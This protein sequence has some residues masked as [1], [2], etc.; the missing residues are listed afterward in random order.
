MKIGRAQIVDEALTL[1]N[2]SGL[3]QL[4]TRKLAERLNIQQP[5]LYYHFK[6]K[7]MLVD[8]MNTRMLAI[9]HTDRFPAV[10]DDWQTYLL[11]NATSFRRALLSHRD[12]ARVHAGSHAETPDLPMAEAQLKCLIDVGFK[13]TLALQVLVT[14][15]R[16][17]VGSVLEQQAEESSPPEAP[18]DVAAFPH[19]SA[20]F[21]H[22]VASSHEANFTAGLSFILDGASK[23][24]DA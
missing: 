19:L 21:S 6:N 5:T 18:G 23:A 4:S 11:A 2:E 22:Y 3:D 8:A 1:L 13:P 17:V 12:G 16:F 9:G 10:G 20:A 14:L 24:L 7:Q 15:S